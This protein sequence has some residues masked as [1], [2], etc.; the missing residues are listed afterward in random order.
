[1]TITSLRLHNFRCF[2]DTGAV[3]IRPL[4]VIFGRN[5]AGKSSLIQAFFLL[6]QTLD[7]PESGERLNIRGP[8]YPAGAY[9]DIVHQ[10][11]AS[12]NIVMEFGVRLSAAKEEAEVRLEFCS[13]EP[14]APRLV[15]LRLSPRR[16]LTVEVRRG[17]GRG[18][19]YELHVDGENLGGERASNF[20]LAVNQF[21]P[22]IGPEPLR[23]GR[24]SPRRELAR[25]LAR[26]TLKQF[27]EDLLAIRAV[28]PFREQPARRYDYAGRPAEAVDLR[29]EAVVHA[30]IDDA[31][32][33]GKH[34]GALLRPINRWLARVGKLRLLPLRRISPTVRLYELRMRD[35]DSGRWANFAD[36]GFGIGQALPVLVE[37]LRTPPA[38]VFIVQE[39][40]IHLHPDAQLAM[41][42]YLVDLAR[43]GRT[44]IVETHSEAVLLRIR[45]AAVRNSSSGSRPKL[46]PEEIAIIHVSGRTTGA[47]AVSSLSVDQLGQIEGWPTGFMEEV[48]KE[49][50]DLLES[51]ARRAEES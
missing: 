19:P 28:G 14:Q 21:L 13:D 50:L 15:S 33:R 31:M 11:L 23:P 34:R 6:R 25:Q 36:V 27:A 37:G 38:G 40:E 30:L 2:R 7:R 3:P 16:G 39:P 51:M 49:R 41:A 20:R 5:N 43:S 46:R 1:M 48:T 18:G 10:H 12:T 47:S 17:R 9:S 4:T 26:V 22:L 44:V 29:G 35:I 24:P 32:R 42:D 8:L 45:G